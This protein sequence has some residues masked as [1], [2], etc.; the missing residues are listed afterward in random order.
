M[1]NAVLLFA[2]DPF[3][4]VALPEAGPLGIALKKFLG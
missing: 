3:L 4:K 1:T 2:V